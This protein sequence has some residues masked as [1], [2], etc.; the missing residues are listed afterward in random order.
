MPSRGGTIAL[1]IPEQDILSPWRSGAGGA[2]ELA[3][4]PA[5]IVFV[6]MFAS[7]ASSRASSA[8]SQGTYHSVSRN[9]LPGLLNEYVWRHD[10]RSMAC[11]LN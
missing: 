3:V 10:R 7:R 8:G 2:V 11:A 4:K 1:E 6:W 9:C 5:P